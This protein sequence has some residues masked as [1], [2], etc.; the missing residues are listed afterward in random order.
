[1]VLPNEVE[2]NVLP[3]AENTASNTSEGEIAELRA[4]AN[5][6]AIYREMLQILNRVLVAQMR[7]RIEQRA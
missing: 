5:R 3:V 1:M 4:S 6:Q 7:R 2:P